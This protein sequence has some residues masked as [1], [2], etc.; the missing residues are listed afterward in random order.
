MAFAVSVPV[1]IPEGE[2][3]EDFHVCEFLFA[4][5]RVGFSF[6]CQR[7]LNCCVDVVCLRIVVSI[8]FGGGAIFHDMSE[9]LFY[10]FRIFD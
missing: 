2:L 10:C 3:P 7:F 6:G 8:L 5:P 9:R 4:R 1:E